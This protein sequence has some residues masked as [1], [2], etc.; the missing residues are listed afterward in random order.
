MRGA[1]EVGVKKI[2]L[3]PIVVVGSLTS[4]ALS[5]T[6]YNNGGVQQTSIQV[7][8][9]PEDEFS[10]KDLGVGVGTLAGNILYVRAKLGYG[11]LVGITGGASYIITG[12]NQQT[13]NT[14]WRSTLGGDYI[15]SPEMITGQKPIHFS[16]PTTIVP[17]GNVIERQQLV[18]EK[19]PRPNDIWVYNFAT[20]LADVPADS[21]VTQELSGRDTSQTAEEMRR[22]VSWEC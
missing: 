8:Q 14:I 16:G 10:W 3:L 11:I 4:P 20:R 15:L 7:S 18:S 19:L 17:S 13:A 12:G 9:P 2:C 22:V 6:P 21:S 1:E 5:Q